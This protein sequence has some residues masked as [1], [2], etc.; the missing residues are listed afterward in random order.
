[1]G[2]VVIIPLKTGNDH[3][4]LMP[5]ISAELAGQ[6][7]KKLTNKLKHVPHGV[8]HALACSFA[9]HHYTPVNSE[10]SP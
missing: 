2:G 1:M 10:P 5:R 9:P 8:E 4:L 3:R 7:L 6:D